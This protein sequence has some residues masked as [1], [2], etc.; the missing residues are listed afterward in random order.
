MTM[1]TVTVRELKRALENVPGDHRV[2]LT[3]PD[4]ELGIT[5]VTMDR[6]MVHLATNNKEISVAETVLVDLEETEE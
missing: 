3:L 6:S 5:C 2:Y 4:N 1:L